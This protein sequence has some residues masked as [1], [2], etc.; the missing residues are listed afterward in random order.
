MFIPAPSRS[1]CTEAYGVGTLMSNYP[2]DF[3]VPE[4]RGLPI[5]LQEYYS[6]YPGSDGDLLLLVMPISKIFRNALPPNVPNMTMTVADLYGFGTG[7][8]AAGRM[9]IALF[10]TLELI[11]DEEESAKCKKAYL[12]QHGD[13]RGWAGEK[14]PHS[15]VWGR[16]RVEKV[17]AFDGFG[18]VA[19]IGWVP[20]EMYREA[21]SKMRSEKQVKKDWPVPRQPDDSGLVSARWLFA[22]TDS[23]MA[24]AA[25]L[26]TCESLGEDDCERLL[27][28]AKVTG[29]GEAVE[30]EPMFTLQL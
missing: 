12:E 2:H 10:G 8:L 30:A 11:T 20:L 28:E 13:A 16:L 5:G 23:S 6:I 22:E 26:A 15:S 25:R 7:N 21:T 9:R 24:D 17:Y 18:D 4:L 27:F 19:Y 14:G 29:S 1:L 3:E